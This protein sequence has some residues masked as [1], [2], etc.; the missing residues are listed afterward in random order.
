M[1]K[2]TLVESDIE[3]GK[4]VINLLIKANFPINY[5]VWLY[6]SDKYEGWRLVIA[7]PKYDDE[8]PLSAY[9]ELNNVIRNHGTEWILWSKKIQLVSTKDATIRSLE[10]DYPSDKPF[11]VQTVSGSTS[12]NIYVEQAYLYP[13][14]KT[15]T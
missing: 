4:Q 8:G 2:T 13:I 15:S 1:D 11:P 9:R 12:D 10:K 5:A 3:K 7:T 6:S 14:H